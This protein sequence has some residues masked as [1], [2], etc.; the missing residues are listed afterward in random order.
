MDFVDEFIFFFS[1]TTIL[2]KFSYFIEEDMDGVVVFGDV[3][4]SCL[5]PILQRFSI[6]RFDLDE[7]SLYGW[8]NL[9]EV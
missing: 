2:F 3:I 4:C 5:Q 7:V 1:L 6:V 9:I 8:V